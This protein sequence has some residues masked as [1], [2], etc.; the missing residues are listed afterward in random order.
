MVADQTAH[1]HCEAANRELVGGRWGAQFSVFTVP[2]LRVLQY[3]VAG[4][5]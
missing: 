3:P 1:E 4:E 5:A 2:L